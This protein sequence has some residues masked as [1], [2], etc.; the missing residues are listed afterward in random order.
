MKPIFTLEELVKL[1]GANKV[2][3]PLRV[4]RELA[5]KFGEMCP[6]STMSETSS[7]EELKP[8]GFLPLE[9][10]NGRWSC[11]W[12]HVV[13]AQPFVWFDKG[14]IRFT[15][16]FTEAQLTAA[17]M[18]ER[19]SWQQVTNTRTPDECAKNLQELY[20]KYGPK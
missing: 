15:P 13:L 5:A 3:F 2:D 9:Q 16:L 14:Q 10:R 7:S 18:R 19:S 1:S 17:V 12:Q 8:F 20:E 6:T 4:D 11:L